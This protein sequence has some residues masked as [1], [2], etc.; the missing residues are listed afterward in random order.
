MKPIYLI[1]FMGAGKTSTAKELSNRLKIPYLDTDYEIEKRTGE[2]IRDIFASKGESYFRDK[3]TEIL[4]ELPE[5]NYVIATGGGIVER[6]INRKTLNAKG[7]VIF[8]HASWN[9]IEK[10]L[11]IDPTRPLWNGKGKK[12]LFDSRQQIYRDTA[13]FIISTDNKNPQS[14]AEEIISKIRWNSVQNY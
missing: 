6:E 3:E 8:L 7:T 11:G 12:N 9:S 10:R 4:L 2:T 14:V 13:E 1:G 5:E